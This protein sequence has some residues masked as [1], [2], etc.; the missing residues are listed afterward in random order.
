MSTAPK[1][2]Y[3]YEYMIALI[4]ALG[5]NGQPAFRREDIK[6]FM[7]KAKDFELKEN[8]VVIRTPT[9]T[10]DQDEASGARI[11][12]QHNITLKRSRTLVHHEFQIDFWLSDLASQIVEAT[13]SDQAETFIGLHDHVKTPEG[14]AVRVEYLGGGIVEDENDDFY[15][16]VLR[17]KFIEPKYKEEH[18]PRLTDENQVEIGVST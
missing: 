13:L 10:P 12:H 2:D 17:L 11:V 5:L 6:E 8:T 15:K 16:V 3:K 4:L 14:D 1:L 9:D 18:V 7:P